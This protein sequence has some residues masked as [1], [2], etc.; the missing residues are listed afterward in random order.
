MGRGQ[1]GSTV[2][3]PKSRQR[4]RQLLWL[5]YSEMPNCPRKHPIVV[6]V[7]IVIVVVVVETPFFLDI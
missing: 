1:A 5:C 3:T 6:V 4:E 2:L 7:V